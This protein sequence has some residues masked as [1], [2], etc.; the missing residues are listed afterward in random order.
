MNALVWLGLLLAVRA[1]TAVSHPDIKF[2]SVGGAIG[3]F[4]EFDALSFYLYENA[5]SFLTEDDLSTSLFL[6]N[7]SS[8]FNSRLAQTNGVVS[9][10]T[11][12]SDEE[13]LVN[14]NFTEFGGEDVLPPLIYNLTSDEV[15][16]LVASSKRDL[17]V[18]G[19][20][21]TMFVDD[22]LIYLGG[23]FEY[24]GSYGAAV[25]NKTSKEV[26]AL[27]FKGF[28]ED[29]LVNAI[30]KLLKDDDVSI[31][32]GGK[33]DTLG[34]ADLLT[35]NLTSSKSK[36]D[37]NTSLITAEQI[38]SLKH[39]YFSNVNGAGDDDALLIC[40]QLSTK[41]QLQEG[42]GGQWGV[43]LPLEMRGLS[44]TKVRLYVPEGD[45]SVQLFRIY[46]YPNNGIMNLSYVDPSTNEIAYCDAW[47]PLLQ[48]TEL[49]QIT[50]DNAD[51]K[52]DLTS[53]DVFV[54]DDGS[55][56]M[57]YSDDLT[58]TLGYGSTYQEFS[59]ENDLEIDK[60]TVTVVGWYGDRGALAGFE[61]Y[62]NSITVYGNNTLNEPNCDDADE[63]TNY[64]TEDGDWQLVTDLALVSGTDYLV[65]VVSD[66]TPKLTL[67]P[68]ISYSG[69]YSIIMTTPGC[70]LDDSCD[71]RAI[72]NVSVID[73]EDRLLTS[74]IIYQ[75]NDNDKFDYLFYGHLN[76]L[77]EY[78]GNN[79]I[80]ISYYDAV[81]DSNETWMVVDKIR[82]DIV[83]LDDYYNVNSTTRNKKSGLL[84]HIKLNGLFEYSLS[85]FS[86][87]DEDL[88]SY[89]VSGTK[90]ISKNNTFVG[91]SSINVLSSQLS[92]DSVISQ[93][94]LDN[95]KLLVLGDL[96][97]SSLDI[98][99]NLLAL[100]INSYN[101]TANALVVAVDTNLRKRD[102]NLKKRDTEIYGATFNDTIA[103]LASVPGGV[104]A[105]GEFELSNATIKDLSSKNESVDS[106]YNIAL[107]SGSTWYSFGNE[108]QLVEF[109]QFSNITIDG[110]EYFV[111]SSDSDYLTWDNTNSKWVESTS[112]QLKIS[113]A[114]NVGRDQ[115]IVGGSSFN[116][117]DYYNDNQAAISD[118]DFLAYNLSVKLGNIFTTYHLNDSV[119]VVG[120]R[121]TAGN[122]TNVAFLN[123]AK[124]TS[125]QA[126]G[127]VEWGDAAVQALYADSDGDLLFIGTNDSV[128]IDS[129]NYTGV[130]IYD[131]T[132]NLFLESQPAQL[133]NDGS[134]I[135][136]TSMVLYDKSNRLLVGGNFTSAG[137]LG[138]QGLCIYD[139][140]DTR[141]LDPATSDDSPSVSGTVTDIKFYKSNEVVI[142]GDLTIDDDD[143]AF[144]TYN[145]DKGTFAKPSNLNTLNSAKVAKFIIND[146][147]DN[148][149]DG[150]YVA[151][152]NDF[153]KGYDGEKWLDLDDGID[154]SASTY[155]SDIKLITL[156]KKLLKSDKYF[157]K[158]KALI[159]SGAFSLSKYGPVNV[160]L[161][162]GSLWIPYVFSTA[163]NTLGTVHSILIK[164]LYRYLSSDD[165]TNRLTG[166]S[167]GKVVGISL[168]C[169]LGLTFL[170]GLL[171]IIPYFFLFRKSKRTESSQRIEE[172]EMMTA[173]NPEDLLH[174]IDLQ[175]HN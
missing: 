151:I 157:D 160:A 104:L 123:T 36:N 56:A 120:G 138:C 100:K 121:F 5:S 1:F 58:R 131:L 66:N 148:N 27:P 108:Y 142:S 11:T 59:L 113:N 146:S 14:G 166:L 8:N 118:N 168:A 13:I 124:N 136:I 17:A 152:G 102:I 77:S 110:V 3:L 90:V 140:D 128:Q 80:E 135:A 164:D 92:S 103:R 60:V 41:W 158:N 126:L 169:A 46:T 50:S 130:V 155:L 95:D 106:A 68:N 52:D 88:V 49:E 54:D 25:Y 117:M 76:G 139:V 4:G 45:D 161:Y 82:A 99:D 30:T 153:V 127:G 32:F 71:N 69:N 97:S 167:K 163:N 154:Y 67:Y 9:Q 24:D 132:K 107:R 73:N 34:L 18:N 53:D 86:S 74:N 33:F 7:T 23:D 125:A 37:T 116:V 29:S 172:K 22:D 44:P 19:N 145:F 81:S 119:S 175:R 133:S 170:V 109:D 114:V 2:L 105:L 16:S 144:V 72:V 61:L 62:S 38:I 12:L 15:T 115:Q 78:D 173:V 134:D 65:L 64:S 83:G 165:I 84:A 48:R 147:G 87:F 137:S 129:S 26:S 149:I 141:W 39:G 174:E 101:T 94:S 43:E 171:Y 159:L 75:N 122:A 93:F 91:N 10:L 21:T 79:K 85:N 20:V 6:R 70:L 162:D 63:T 47:C 28:G 57:Y 111:F 51:D 143:V 150:R 89:N 156:S 98:N 55:L 96:L 35:H 112:R 42:V 31:I 40:P